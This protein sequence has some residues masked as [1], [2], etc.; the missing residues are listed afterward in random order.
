MDSNSLFIPLQFKIDIFS[1]LEELLDRKIESV[2]ISPVKRELEILSKEGSPELRKKAKFALA[3]GSRCIYVRVAEKPSEN[4]DDSIVRVAKEW[5]S[6]VFT[7]DKALR[8]KLRDIS[9]P[10]I[11]LRQ[12]VQLEIDGLIS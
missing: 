1:A 4:T 7:N 6:P 5:K 2:L 10:V 8:K 12:K 3:L 9:V 11:Y